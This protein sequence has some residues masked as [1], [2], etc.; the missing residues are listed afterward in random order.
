M[1]IK[2]LY[3]IC[4]GN[5]L[6]IFSLE[7]TIELIPTQPW[8]VVEH[9]AEPAKPSSASI[10]RLAVIRALMQHPNVDVCR[11]CQ[12]LLG[13]PT[14]KPT[15]LLVLNLP[16]LIQTLHKWRVRR[17]L[18]RQ[19]A[20]GIDDQ[21]RWQTTPLKEYPPAMCGS[22]AEGLFGTISAWPCTAQP[23]PPASDIDLWQ[24]L[25]ATVYGQYTGADFAGG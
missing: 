25:N 5:D 1:T 4:I 10:W 3:Q 8:A 13:A 15:Q 24:E 14:P 2:E 6:V 23:A 16:H 22:L 12:G 9:P 18:P 19:A 17:E 11:F 21:G 20:I 7:A